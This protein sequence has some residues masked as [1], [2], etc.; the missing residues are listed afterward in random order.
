MNAK[1]DFSYRVKNQLKRL[2]YEVKQGLITKKNAE[3]IRKFHS[4]TISQGLSLRRQE[5]YIG[6]L[7]RLAR[8]V[9][10]PF[11]EFTKEDVKEL[12][13]KVELSKLSQWSKVGYKQA[14]RHLWM[15]ID[16]VDWNEKNYPERVKWMKITLPRPEDTINPDVL[17]RPEE[18]KKMVKVAE[19][20]QDKAIIMTLFES[21][22]RSGEFLGM[23][24]SSVKP[25]KNGCYLTANGKTGRR[26]ILVINSAP[27]IERWLAHHPLKDDPTA[28]LWICEATNRKNE[29]LGERGL[30]EKLK[31]IAKRAGITGRK[32]NPH[33]WR[34]ASAS[35][36]AQFLPEAVM[37]KYY[38]WVKDSKM[39]AVYVHLS[40]K[41][42]DDAILRLHGLDEDNETPMIGKVKCPRCS[43]E[44]SKGCV[45]C[46]ICGL[47]L[48]EKHSQEELIMVNGEPVSKDVI[49]GLVE[50]IKQELRKELKIKEGT[51]N[52]K[53]KD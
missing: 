32:I 21:G 52:G 36:M 23:T 8:G 16:G 27:L 42:V 26:T 11:D 9:K 14:I 33:S 40:G 15:L 22:F 5:W 41:D 12:V 30:Q 17:I 31:E 35:Y 4:E 20:P 38:G 25:V 47:C 50:M 44:V 6:K 39:A 19:T 29:P 7:R 1:K 45:Y 2:E 10:K 13:K 51:V 18:V 37:K 24:I 3:W 43:N 34:K 46:P 49:N 48:D 28:P 53:H